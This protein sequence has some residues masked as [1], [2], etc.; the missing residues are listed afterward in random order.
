MKRLV[1]PVLLSTLLLSTALPGFSE[2]VRVTITTA[3]PA[4]GVFLTPFWVGFHDGSFDTYDRDA[5]VSAGLERLVEDG[6][7]MPLSDEFSAALADGIQATMAGPGGPLF[8]GDSA[9]MIFD[10]DASDISYFSYASMVIPSNDAF[11]SN[12][13]PTV[14][15]IFDP[16]G[17]FTPVTFYVLGA[18]VLDAGTEVND[19]LES[20]TAALGQAAPDTGTDENGVVTTHPG[21]LEGGRILA[22]R[23]DGQFIA[24]GYRLAKVT[25][26]LA[27]RT[28]VTF[29]GS[30]DQ[31]APAVVTDASAACS[32]ML[33][34]SQDRLAVHCEHDV[35]NVAAA[36]VHS[37]VAGENGSVIFTFDDPLMELRQTFD[38][39]PAD[40]ETFFGRGFY[41]NIHSVIVPSGEVRAQIDGCF[42]GPEGLCLQTERFQV[43]AS[44][45][46]DGVQGQ[47]QAVEATADAGQFTF[48]DPDNVELDVK[49]LDGCSVNSHYWVFIAG[50]T[51]VGVETTLTDT[52]TG[53]MR[54][55][56]NAEGEGFEL[57]R[58]IEAFDCM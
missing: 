35:E 56:L 30:G 37:G 44:F 26:D 6:N 41:V 12:G 51:D 13:N 1:R 47:A 28:R 32:A 19:E 23:D 42:E 10:L 50:L 4:D 14:H 33:N 7:T 11:V 49:V 18:E 46:V 34:A 3:V 31:E 58:D 29:A 15:R 9:T 27:P 25:I 39:T 24:P 48:F 16:D 20:S 54:I 40:V 55:Y 38:V 57:V 53:A 8:A 5:A 22:A 21:H 17:N 2:E 52:A 36:H 43:E 45:T